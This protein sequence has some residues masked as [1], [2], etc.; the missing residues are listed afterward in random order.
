M[1]LAE[2]NAIKMHLNK[3][4]KELESIQITCLR[5]EHLKSGHRCEKF[6]AKPPAEWLHGPID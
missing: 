2:L 3:Q 4:L 6:D 1:N 5:C